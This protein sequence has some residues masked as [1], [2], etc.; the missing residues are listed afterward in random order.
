MKRKRD[1]PTRLDAREVPAC[2]GAPCPACGYAAVRE[3]AFRRVCTECGTVVDRMT[4][5]RPEWTVRSDSSGADSVRTETRNP[6]LPA[7]SL[8]AKIVP[9]GRVPYR[10]FRM[11]KLNN[12]SALTSVERC[13]CAVYSRIEAV[14]NV[15]RV[16]NAIQ[17]AAKLL[18]RQVYAANLEKHQRGE[19]REGLRGTRR[20]G[21]VAA[22]IL[23]AHK[24]HG[25]VLR[26]NAAAKMFHIT[27]RN[28]RAGVGIFWRLMQHRQL[29]AR[30]QSVV[31]CKYYIR[32]YAVD[33][34]LP[35]AAA[36]LA[37]RLAKRF[38][39]CGLASGKQPQSI[40]A[41]T[42][43]CVAQT[44]LPQPERPALDA[45]CKVVD[46]S[47][48]TVRDVL[49]ATQAEAPGQ[50]IQV[51]AVEVCE[52]LGIMNRVTQHTVACV[53]HA[54]A[55]IPATDRTASAT[56]Y[57]KNDPLALAGYALFFAATLRGGL[58]SVTPSRLLDASRLTP[59]LTD[60][61]TSRVI[62]FRDSIIST[63]DSQP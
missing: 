53:A 45:F 55:R 60:Q 3:G 57:A 5:E 1:V 22:C 35:P 2:Q 59:E 11:I 54:L 49:K 16:E 56:L 51:L 36:T 58:P 14:C 52:R 26:K 20:D 32:W 50:L 28:V 62:W 27:E 38:K 39:R 13:L 31:S 37:A 47:R 41:T 4:D 46:V 18:F 34:D 6:L 24:S 9:S 25:V 17:F 7:A 10:Q 29:D 40:A 63:C 61:L 30:L 8:L 33:L 23:M 44:L 48:S 42:L 43:W 15:H 12:W 21:L 19:K